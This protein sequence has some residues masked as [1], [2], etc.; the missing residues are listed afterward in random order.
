M[1]TFDTNLPCYV[2]REFVEFVQNIFHVYI[3][4]NIRVYINIYMYIYIFK[5]ICVNVLIDA[6]I[7]LNIQ[8]ETPCYVTRQFIEFVQNIL[9]GV[10][11]TF[12]HIHIHIHMH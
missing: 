7:N 5:Y 4:V 8:K 2:S 9:N 11:F 10:W 6:L 12:I 3:C 1:I